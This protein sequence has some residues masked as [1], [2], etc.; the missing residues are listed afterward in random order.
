MDILICD[1]EKKNNLINILNNIE[2]QFLF[3]KFTDSNCDTVTFKLIENDFKIVD[4]IDNS[5]P[6]F[7][8]I[9]GHPGAGKSTILRTRKDIL[10]YDIN[11][12]T[13]IDPDDIRIFSKGYRKNI[14]GATAFVSDKSL[15]KKMFIYKL[16]TGKFDEYNVYVE[17]GYI[18]SNGNFISK[19]KLMDTSS[20]CRNMVRD[21]THGN[22]NF[23]KSLLG[24][25]VDKNSNVIF[26]L[27]CLDI[28]ICDS[29]IRYFKDNNYKIKIICIYTDYQTGLDRVKNRIKYDGRYISTD[30]YTSIWK[31]LWGSSAGNTIYDHFKTKYDS[32]NIIFID[33]NN[34][35]EISPIMNAPQSQRTINIKCGNI[36][37]NLTNNTILIDPA[38]I[39]FN[40][41]TYFGGG[42]SGLIYSHFKIYG[43]PHNFK[44]KIKQTEAIYNNELNNQILGIKGIIHAYGPNLKPNFFINLEKTIKSINTE[45]GKINIDEN[46]EIRFP[47]ISSGIFKPRNIDII[48]I[49]VNIYN[50][51]QKNIL[52]NCK[53]YI[54][55]Y[56]KTNCDNIKSK[57]SQI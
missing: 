47:L 8:L 36:L 23:S 6:E 45:L 12:Y 22:W 30:Y 2:Q 52:Y 20:S 3:K 1:L 49:G 13:Y 39:M 53:I 25:C 40:G 34:T 24:K 41:S 54:Y 46:T 43:K 16:P 50:Y 31:A 18:D 5:Q 14:N 51:I 28:S 38:G 57:L 11:T 19:Y 15:Q 26:S 10:S 7:V 32:Q 17:D 48:D 21:I 44:G 35:K 33:N 4:K 55:I 27:T 37:E 9:V 42:L 56:N 29:I